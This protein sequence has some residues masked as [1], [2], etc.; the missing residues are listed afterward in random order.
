MALLSQTS[1]PG[2][3]MFI[4]P[5]ESRAASPIRPYQA[6][7]LLGYKCFISQSSHH[8]EVHSPT[9]QAAPQSVQQ[10][11]AAPSVPQL[12]RSNACRQS[13]ALH[14]SPEL[15]GGPSQGPL[16]VLERTRPLPRQS[17]PPRPLN[18]PV[19]NSSTGGGGGDHPCY[20]SPSTARPTGP[21][22]AC[23]L[24]LWP[25]TLQL[26]RS[27]PEPRTRTPKPGT[28]GVCKVWAPS[29]AVGRDL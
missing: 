21:S 26:I 20:A 23:L 18:Q 19:R 4:L 11:Q 22:S 29:A 25:G 17:D 2:V 16:Q 27:T 12:S 6:G 1:S 9:V 14:R 15:T 10:L 13:P 5:L 28:K 3:G 24:L 8:S 7:P